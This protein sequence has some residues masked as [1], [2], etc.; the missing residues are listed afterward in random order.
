MNKYYSLDVK[1]NGAWFNV[2]VPSPTGLEAIT[3]IY[4]K[5]ETIEDFNFVDFFVLNNETI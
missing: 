5:Y 1:K 4:A 2:I 3:R